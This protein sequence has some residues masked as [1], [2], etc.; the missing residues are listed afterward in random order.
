M[1]KATPIGDYTGRYHDITMLNGVI[2]APRFVQGYN[3]KWRKI[4][5][6][7]HAISIHEPIHF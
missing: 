1:I 7:L 3:H 6:F 5:S 2:I 4:D